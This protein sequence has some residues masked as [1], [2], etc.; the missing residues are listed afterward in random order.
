M[1]LRSLIFVSIL[2]AAIAFPM[3]E[4]QLGIIGNLL[5]LL[6]IQGILYCTPT[7]N[8]GVN[9]TATPVFPNALVQLQCGDGNVVSSA[10]TNAS[11]L[12]SMLLDPLN[13]LLSTLLS[14][15]KLVVGTPLATCNASLPSIGTLESTLKFIGNTLLGILNVGN[16]IPTGFQL[17]P[18]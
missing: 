15:C 13:F 14:N 2:F 4:A 12:F 18:V 5:G 7:G 3:A 17:I 11:G 10:T 8:I 9:G 1:A 16:I 6:R